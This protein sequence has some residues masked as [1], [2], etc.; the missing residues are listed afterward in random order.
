MGGLQKTWKL[1][2]SY[3]FLVLRHGHVW[4]S[5]KGK[6]SHFLGWGDHERVQAVQRI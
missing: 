4:M 5:H 2:R 6:V 3:R 1:W